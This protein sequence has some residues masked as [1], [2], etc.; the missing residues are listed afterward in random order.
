MLNITQSCS[1]M[2]MAMGI[3]YLN[4]ETATENAN[5]ITLKY[6]IGTSSAN[7]LIFTCDSTNTFLVTSSSMVSSVYTLNI[8]SKYA[9]HL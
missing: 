4:T 6:S 3:G 8:K 1:R 7:I 2:I 5:G 9:C